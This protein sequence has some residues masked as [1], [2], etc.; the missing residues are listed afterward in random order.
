MLTIRVKHS[1]PVCEK[2]P[3]PWESYSSSPRPD[4]INVAQVNRFNSKKASAVQSS[5]SS[6]KLGVNEIVEGVG[7]ILKNINAVRD[8]ETMNRQGQ[9]AKLQAHGQ[10]TGEGVPTFKLAGTNPAPMLEQGVGSR[11]K[12]WTIDQLRATDAMIPSQ[13]GTNQFASQKGMTGFGTPRNTTTPVL[14]GV[15][16]VVPEPVIPLQY[17]T[18]QFASQKGMTGF[19]S[20]RD[21]S[22]KHLHRLWEVEYPEHAHAHM[23]QAVH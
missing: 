23:D 11:S 9:T 19:G 10:I 4:N 17:G 1:N 8:I 15:E 3:P 16:G 14:G 13:M 22:G 20:P 18:N 5:P 21:V 7:K 6:Q 2:M 12:R